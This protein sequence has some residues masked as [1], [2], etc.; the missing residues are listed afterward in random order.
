MARMYSRKKG[1]SGSS[2]IDKKENR[3]WVKYN[4]EESTK[5]VLKFAKTGKRSSEIGMILRDQYGIPSIKELT[6]KTIGTLLKE[7]KASPN[8][9]EDLTNLIKRHI[10]IQKHL[11]KNHKDMTGKRGLQLTESKIRRLMKY[12]KSKKVLPQDW[13]YNKEKARLI[14]G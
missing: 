12:Y 13:K 9:P 10:Q 4:A 1:K 7:N 8:L 5:L 14:I 3:E 11:E 6:G 2:V